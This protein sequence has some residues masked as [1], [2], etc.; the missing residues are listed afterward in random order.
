MNCRFVIFIVS[1]IGGIVCL[2]D[3]NDERHIHVKDVK[4][5]PARI[6]SDSAVVE[7]LDTSLAIYEICPRKTQGQVDPDKNIPYTDMR[8]LKVVRSDV[9][10]EFGPKRARYTIGFYDA[11]PAGQFY[12]QL[13]RLAPAAAVQVAQI[14]W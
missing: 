6:F 5:G 4:S 3:E 13:S 8:N 10:F 9:Q 12:H 2:L 1:L 7:L 14:H 11:I